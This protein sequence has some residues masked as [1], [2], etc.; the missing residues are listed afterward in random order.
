MQCIHDECFYVS[1]ACIVVCY[2]C[3]VLFSGA[4]GDDF[5][6]VDSDDE[7]ASGCSALFMDRV[8]LPMCTAQYPK[9]DG[10]SSAPVMDKVFMYRLLGI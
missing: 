9:R 10:R 1:L 6:S 4:S 8:P 3:S 7:N 2:V 5:M